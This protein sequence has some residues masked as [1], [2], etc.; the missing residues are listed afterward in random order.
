GIGHAAVDTDPQFRAALAAHGYR[1]DRTGEILQLAEYVGPFSAR[2]TQIGRNADRYE[3]EW[4]AAHPGETP[5]SVLRR[6]WDAR[7]WAEGRPDK[8]L[9]RPGANLAERWLGE[10]AALGY[11][12]VDVSVALTSPPAGVCARGAAP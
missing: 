5:G 6:R 3:R 11:R 12:D 7:A 2:A 1:L 10:L 9:P 4:T 8:V